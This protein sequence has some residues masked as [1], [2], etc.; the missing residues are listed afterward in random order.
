MLSRFCIQY[1]GEHGK[2]EKDIILKTT[3]TITTKK[4]LYRPRD[5]K[6]AR[7]GARAA[8]LPLAF[9]CGDTGL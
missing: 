6:N 8:S 7:R 9:A 5:R 1:I 2:K 3:T 4:T